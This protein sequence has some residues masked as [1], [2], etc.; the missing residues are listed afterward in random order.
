MH[1]I[2][3]QFVK[4]KGNTRLQLHIQYLYVCKSLTS[5]R[6]GVCYHDVY[7]RSVAE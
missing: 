4:C 3:V 1:D 7:V 5:K 2:L 6:D